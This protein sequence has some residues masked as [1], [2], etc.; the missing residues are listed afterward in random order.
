[1]K[2]D[3]QGISIIVIFLWLA[4]LSFLIF[5][6]FSKINRLFGKTKS[7]TFFK[8]IEDISKNE[9]KNRKSIE[10]FRNYFD[11]F[12]QKSLSDVQK[13]GIVRFNPFNETGG[14]HSF[15]IALLNGRDSGFVL[16]GLHTRER[17]RLYLKPIKKGGSEYDLSN[18]EKQ[19][20]KRAQKEG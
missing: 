2:F 19:A 7:D 15:S 18:E 17:T 16:T 13:V 11:A 5:F 12:E 3:W 6:F 9:K 8:L 10:E 1:M 14:D 20:I 4:G